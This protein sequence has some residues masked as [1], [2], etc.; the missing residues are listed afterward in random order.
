MPS[1]YHLT[2]AFGSYQHL[3]M[4]NH[5]KMVN[6]LRRTPQTIR[7]AGHRGH[8]WGAPE[9]TLSAFRMAYKIAG[10]GVVC[11]TDLGITRDGELILIHGETVDRTTDG[12]GLVRDMDYSEI[13]K[14]RRTN[15]SSKGRVIP[16][17]GTWYYFHLELKIYDRNDEIF[18][19]SRAI[20]DELHCPD[21]LLFSSFDF[22]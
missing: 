19:K 8:S 2:R 13:I 5:T 16:S 7:I 12:Q 10:K 11:E 1:H 14:R 17:S 18:S 9:N 15:I 20:I 22:A 6:P 21:L 3:S 4:E